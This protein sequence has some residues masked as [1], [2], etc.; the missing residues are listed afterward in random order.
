MYFLLKCYLLTFYF[1]F[2]M[3]I[4]NFN[5]SVIKLFKITFFITKKTKTIFIKIFNNLMFNKPQKTKKN[6]IVIIKN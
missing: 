2:K 6:Y 5:L 4:K 3:N 1:C